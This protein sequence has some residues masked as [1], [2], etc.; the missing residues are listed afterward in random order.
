M[1][2]QLKLFS[3]LILSLLLV[4][5]GG[6]NSNIESKPP[7]TLSAGIDCNLSY[8]NSDYYFLFETDP[9]IGSQWYLNNQGQ[10]LGTIN[11]DIGLRTAW[12]KTK[13]KGVVVAVLDDA[14]ELTHPDLSKNVVSGSKSF[15]PGNTSNLPLPCYIQKDSHGTAVAGIILSTANN[16][17]GISG[18]A[19]EASLIAYDVLS[20]GIEQDFYQALTMDNQRISIYHNSWGSP[21]TGAIRNPGI[22]FPLAIRQG[23]EQGRGGLGS[24]FVFSSGNGGSSDNTNLDGIVNQRGIITVCAVNDKGTSLSSS[25]PGANILVCAPGAGTKYNILTTSLQ[26]SY[27]NDFSGSSAAA[28][29]VS[30][31]IALMLSIRPDLTYRDVQLILAKTARKNDPN[32]REWKLARGGSGWIHPFYGYGIVNADAAVNLAQTWTSVGNSQ[33]QK[34]CTTGLIIANQSIP[35]FPNTGIRSSVDILCPQIEKIEFVEIEV[36]TEHNNHGDLRI[37]IETAEGNVSKLADARICYPLGVD[38]CGAYTKWK[39]G[40]LHHI[41]ETSSGTWS[42]KI[43]DQR[44]QN[45]GSLISWQLTLYGR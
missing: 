4:G 36:T 11:E 13:G 24:I 2:D 26:G 27:R 3:S 6:S 16:G 1:L 21:D 9:L 22:F 20:S 39:F 15:R 44:L 31:V 14:V 45:I 33:K 17:V 7:T 35:D 29:M 38:P 5:C 25:E 30:G 19:P 40:S 28:P 18:I 12:S 42:L 37:E 23:I 41:D 32:N 10:S 34:T 43:T 8:T